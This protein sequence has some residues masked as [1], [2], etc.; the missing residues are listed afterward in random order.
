MF[1][2]TK[3]K[4]NP[5]QWKATLKKL[6][7][8]VNQSILG[9]WLTKDY[10]KRDRTHGRSITLTDLARE[11]F[12]LKPVNALP[13]RGTVKAG[14]EGVQNFGDVKEY[15][16]VPGAVKKEGRYVLKVQGDSMIDAFI[17][18]D[19]YVVVEKVEDLPLNQI[20]IALLN[21]NAYIK[22]LIKR[23]DGQIILRSENQVVPLLSVV[24]HN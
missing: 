1:Q 17:N 13:L 15:V 6:E 4:K 20:A 16:E 11:Y 8:W 10:I 3:I 21:G 23:S 24:R 5:V 12:G 7:K 22:K 9:S 14:P 19:D 2:V 18:E